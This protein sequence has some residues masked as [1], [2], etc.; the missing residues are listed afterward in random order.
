LEIYEY[1][2]ILKTLVFVSSG[3]KTPLY[4]VLIWKNTRIFCNMIKLILILNYIS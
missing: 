1:V 3:Q 2:V 4:H